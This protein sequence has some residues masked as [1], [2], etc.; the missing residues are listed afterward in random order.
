MTL[1]LLWSFNF[2][3][4]CIK[5]GKSDKPSLNVRNV[6][7]FFLYKMSVRWSPYVMATQNTTIPKMWESSTIHWLHGVGWYRI[8]VIC[9][10]EA[11]IILPGEYFFCIQLRI[12]FSNI[13]KVLYRNF[14]AV[15]F[16]FDSAQHV[17]TRVSCA[18]STIVVASCDF[19]SNLAPISQTWTSIARGASKVT[20][21]LKF[22]CTYIFLESRL[23]TFLCVPI[24]MYHTQVHHSYFTY[25]KFSTCSGLGPWFSSDPL[26]IKRRPACA[27]PARILKLPAIYPW[28]YTD[29]VFL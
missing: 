25:P 10:V 6:E 14:N 27:G 15:L 22:D 7:W 2:G 3:A 8:L 1:T 21:L 19:C 4:L 24:R 20:Q 13:L 16:I 29:V 17:W 12:C 23:S 9:Y 11:A 5:N 18:R 28:V 26:H